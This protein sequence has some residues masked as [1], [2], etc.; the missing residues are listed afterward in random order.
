MHRSST[1]LLVATLAIAAMLGVLVYT[2]PQSQKKA[3]PVPA[4]L[5]TILLPEAHRIGPFQL[6]DTRGGTLDAASLQGSW[7]LIFFGYTHCPDICPT[8]LA[9]LRNMAHAL[10]QRP[11]GTHPTRFIFVSVDPGR[12]TLEQL[13][14]YVGYF[15]PQFIG[16]TGEK[17]QIDALTRQLGAVYLFDGDTQ[18]DSYIVNHSAGIAVVDPQG[19]WVARFNPP[20]QAAQMATR[21]RL[22]QDYFQ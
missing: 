14:Q 13:Q 19:R 10:E 9:T 16:A 12:D 15:H 4:E 5:A 21:F 1:T 22:L 3:P 17:A 11:A 8:T 18:S 2:L 20:H 6:R 7:S